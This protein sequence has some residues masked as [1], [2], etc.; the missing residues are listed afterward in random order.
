VTGTAVAT[1]QARIAEIR[2]TFAAMSP[3]R[4]TPMGTGGTDF[5]AALGRAENEYRPGGAGPVTGNDVVAAAT[6]YLGVPYR[7]GGADPATGLDCSGFV[8][9]VYDDLGIDLPRVS[10][11]QAKV[12]TA[13]PDLASARAGDLIAFGDPVDHIGIY[14]GNGRMIVAPHTGEVVRVEDVRPDWTAIR[15]VLPETTST[16]LGASPYAA[17][18]EQAGARYGIDPSVL[19]AVARAESGYNPNAVSPAGAQGLM[20]LM[21][22]TAR[23]LGVDP[24]DPAQAVD[25]AARLLSD[26]LQQFGSL[27][28]ALAAYNAGPGA[29]SRYGGI[30]PYR[31]TE[32]Y[33]SR[34][35]DD[36]RTE[37]P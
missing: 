2:A 9:Q 16:S 26:H 5:A 28:L 31:E 37:G 32:G 15:R 25:G 4:A 27:D 36:L 35:L 7:W 17:L 30:P 1:A 33:V 12:G 22:G 20:Q 19:A 3:P 23:G 6:R 34:I 14:I 24:L 10:R 21:P 18:F 8:Q 13:V 11:D 29:V